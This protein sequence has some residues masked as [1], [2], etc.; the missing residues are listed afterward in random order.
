M[1]SLSEIEIDQKTCNF[2]CVNIQVLQFIHKH[3][4]KS[5]KVSH[6]TGHSACKNCYITIYN[7][8]VALSINQYVLLFSSC[9]KG[10]FTFKV[11]SLIRRKWKQ[12]GRCQLL[13][14]TKRAVSMFLKYLKHEWEGQPEK[15]NLGRNNRINNKVLDPKRHRKTFQEHIS[16]SSKDFS[17]PQTCDGFSQNQDTKRYYEKGASHLDYTKVT[18]ANQLQGR[19]VSSSGMA[20]KK[21]GLLYFSTS[22]P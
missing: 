15:H 14:T 22:A 11:L 20:C 6:S 3:Y 10:V 5:K 21:L 2:T 7:Y 12:L 9:Y 8:S 19:Q 13:E 1:N 16:Q 4:K 17:G 18:Q